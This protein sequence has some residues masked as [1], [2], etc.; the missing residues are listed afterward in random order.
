LYELAFARVKLKSLLICRK[1]IVLHME[2]IKA[3]MHIVTF[4]KSKRGMS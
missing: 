3:E 2:L 4:S 1:S